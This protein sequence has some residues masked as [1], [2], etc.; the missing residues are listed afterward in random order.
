MEYAV[1]MGSSAVT[2]TM[3]H[4]TLS[5]FQKLTGGI[6]RQHREA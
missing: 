6:Q 5:V 1:E 2:H 4:K 3:F